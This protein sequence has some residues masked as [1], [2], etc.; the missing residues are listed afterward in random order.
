M[1]AIYHLV[2]LTQY[3]HRASHSDHPDSADL[4]VYTLLLE[5][6]YHQWLYIYF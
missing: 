1:S 3:M 4:T 2:A 5:Y 6:I